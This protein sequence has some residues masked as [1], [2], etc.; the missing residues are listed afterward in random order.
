LSSLGRLAIA[1][2]GAAIAL[3]LA[4]SP[5]AATVS[6]CSTMTTTGLAFSPYV[7]SPNPVD[8]AGSITITCTGSGATNSLN[9]T[10]SNGSSGACPGRRMA[11][12]ANRLNYDIFQDAG[13]ITPW[14]AGAG[15]RLNFNLDFST[16]A[17]QTRTFTLYGRMPGNQNPPYGTTYSDSLTANLRTSTGTSLKTVT[18]PITGSI[19]PVCSA[20]TTPLAFGSYVPTAAS[21]GT[22]T[23]TVTCTNTAPY[24]ISLGAGANADVAS[25]RM[26]GPSSGRLSYTLYS[27]AARTTLWGDGTTFGSKVSATGTGGAQARTVYGTIPAGQA[28]TP[29]NYSDSVLVTVEY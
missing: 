29:G 15:N 20:S 3:V 24:Q 18:V 25:R 14:C 19:S 1:L 28:P 8:G 27:N 5:A 9:I 2:L 7:A 13:R 11:M 23:V 16:G 12:G 26:A 21:L 17:N 6:S 22:G 10:L 4:P